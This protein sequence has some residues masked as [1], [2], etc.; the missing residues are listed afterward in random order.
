MYYRERFD[1]GWRAAALQN[2]KPAEWIVPDK[3]LLTFR[4]GFTTRKSH[5]IKKQ[6]IPQQPLRVLT[7]FYR[8]PFLLQFLQSH[9]TCEH[10]SPVKCISLTRESITQEICLSRVGKHISPGMW[11]RRKTY[12]GETHITVTLQ[13]YEF[14]RTMCF[15]ENISPEKCVFPTREHMS[16]GI[17]F[18][19]NTS[20][21]TLSVYFPR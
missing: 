8:K 1:T 5:T 20:D 14:P 15:P 10:I 3:S 19:G 9:G 21:Q 13:L 4:Q 17:R 6:E 2:W 11:V 12:H 16:L 7:F 18:R